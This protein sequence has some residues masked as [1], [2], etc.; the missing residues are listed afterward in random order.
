MAYAEVLS[1]IAVLQV[2]RVRVLR[3][4]ASLSVVAADAG[5]AHDR[6][7]QAA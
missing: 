7:R 2:R 6:D 5:H 3:S 4:P 1:R